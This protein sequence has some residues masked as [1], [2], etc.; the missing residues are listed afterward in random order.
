MGAAAEDPLRPDHDLRRAGG[1]AGRAKRKARLGTGGGRRCGAQPRLPH[2][3]LPPGG[4]QR[5]KPDRLCR[6]GGKEDAPADAGKQRGSEILS[7]KSRASR[8]DALL[9]G[10]LKLLV[11]DVLIDGLGGSLACAHGLDDGGCAGDSVAAGIHALAAGLALVALGDDTAVPVGFEARRGGADERIGAGA[12]TH[13]DGVHVHGELAALLLDGAAAAGGIRLTQLHLDAGD[14]PDEAVLAGQDLHGVAEGLEDDALLLGVLD[15]LLTGGQLG[16][17]AAVD[18]VD[19]LG[20][21][22]EGAAGSVHC[23][24][25][26]AHDRHLF[27]G[28]DG[29]LADGEI[30]LHQVGAGEELV[31]GVDALQAL[32]GDAH[33]AGQTGTGTHEDGL[34]AVLAHQFV[35]GQHLADD[36]VALEIDAHLPEA[37]DL[38]LDDGLGQTELGDAVHQ[39]AASHVQSLVDRDLVAQLGQITG[40]SQ[41]GRAC[42]D[43]GDLVAVGCRHDG[44]G[45]DVLAVPVGHEA[46]Q[47]ADADRLILDAAGALA[48]ALALLRADAAAD[49][50]Q[51]GGAVDDL[52]GGL[53]VALG[54]MADELGDVD[55]D[56]AAG[57]AGLILAVDAAL[58]LVHGHF[59]GVAQS[60]FL[61]ILVADVGVL[62]GHGALFGVHIE[63]HLTFPPES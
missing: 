60:H 8:R 16:H 5:R 11:P 63:S 14:G 38:L 17:A 39:H 23:H 48:L 19:R 52:I 55:A 10:Y 34:V 59:G 47:T 26:A 36:H 43:D 51:G 58:G 27:A 56:G 25:A 62:S 32:A 42:A 9:F 54:H 28:A 50:G 44:S 31:G 4:G 40:S 13:D 3:A 24:I 41:A 37:V 2:R 20:T 53:E 61:K 29:G 12:Q 18:D 35:D 1:T 15:L 45:V 49:G 7:I 46:L 22:T 57:L 33:E 21:Q 30:G 6:R